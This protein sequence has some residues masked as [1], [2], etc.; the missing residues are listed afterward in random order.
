MKIL[1][2]AELIFYAGAFVAIFAV[3]AIVKLIHSEDPLPES[4]GPC[5]LDSGLCELLP[6]KERFADATIQ[7]EEGIRLNRRINTT[8]SLP[9]AVQ[10]AQEVKLVLEGRDMYLGVYEYPLRKQTD[11]TWFSK[12]VVPL[13]TDDRMQWVLKVQMKDAMGR[14]KEWAY[15]FDIENPNEAI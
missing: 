13:C 4:L 3:A 14:N 9:K 6:T 15:L 1:S 2:K 8:L 12:V 10:N 11:N 5:D 7:F